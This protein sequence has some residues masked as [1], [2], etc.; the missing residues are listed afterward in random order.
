MKQ[1]QRPEDDETPHIA[2]HPAFIEALQMELQDYHDAL[3]FH[4]EFQLT[5][6]PLRIDCVVVR[7][8]K[9]IEI[10]KNIAAIFREWNLIEYK[11]PGKSVSVDD[12]YKVYAYAC[13]Y[14]SFQKVPI[15]GVTIT[16]VENYVSEKLLNHLRNE[17]GYTIVEAGQGIYNVEG[18]VLP[19]Q[20]IN[21]GELPEEGNLWLRGLS[22]DLNYS[23]F[24]KISA[25]IG[26]QGTAARISAYLQAIAQANPAA[27]KEAIKMSDSL[28][29]EKVFEEV[30]WIAKWEARGKAEEREV[31]QN[32]VAD[33]NA[34]IAH[35]DAEIARLREQLRIN[36]K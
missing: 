31:W 19:I 4:P 20:I 35:K 9:D 30:G 8:T 11:S 26:R 6:G 16:F 22:N 29:L 1:K 12:F 10:K 17:R 24:G 14:I 25:E 2:W 27:L 23:A 3:E 32:V 28:T 33:K 34:E 36:S 13:L 7:K 5:S 21:S 15:T 18:D